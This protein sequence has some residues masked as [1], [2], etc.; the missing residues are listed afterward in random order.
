MRVCCRAMDGS[1][2]E[3]GSRQNTTR[4]QS[5]GNEQTLTGVR[6]SI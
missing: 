4:T 5:N 6:N 1:F 3:G 2:S